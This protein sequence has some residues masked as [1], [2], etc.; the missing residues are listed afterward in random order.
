MRKKMNKKTAGILAWMLSLYS[1]FMKPMI[2]FAAADAE[3]VSRGSGSSFLIL[4]GGMLVVIAIVVVIA[5]V[6]GVISAVAAEEDNEE[7]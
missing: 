7:E 5:A 2:T 1:L 4:A 6:S 3:A